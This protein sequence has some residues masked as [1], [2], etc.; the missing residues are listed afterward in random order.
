MAVSPYPSLG[1]SRLAWR[2]MAHQL[3]GEVNKVTREKE[4][5]T[6][7]VE[8]GKKVKKILDMINV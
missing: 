1:E 5:W 7:N 6:E 2:W 3:V 8:R 4:T